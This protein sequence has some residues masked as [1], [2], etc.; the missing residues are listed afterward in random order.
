M[1]GRIEIPFPPPRSSPPGRIEPP[2]VAVE[3]RWEY[4]EVVRSLKDQGPLAEAELNALGDEHWEMAGVVTTGE[5][6]HF[7]FKRARLP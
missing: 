5:S 7:Y 1:T 2:M 6:V 3:P 4:K